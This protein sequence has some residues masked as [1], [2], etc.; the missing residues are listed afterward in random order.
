MIDGGLFPEVI[1]SRNIQGVPSVYLNGEVFAN[2]KID[3]A[4]LLEKLI[5]KY[6]ITVKS[7]KPSLPLQDVTVIGGGPAGVA[8]AIYSARK[9][10]N[11]TMIADRI[12][13]QVKD[14]MGIEN[15]ISVP[16]TTGP[17]LSNALQGHMDDYDIT[18]KSGL[19]VTQVEKGEIKRIHL[20][21]GEVIESKTMIIATGAKWREL[22]IP[23]E[24]EN[25]GNGVAYCPHCDGPFFKVKDVAVVGGGNSGI[26]AALDLA[27]IVKSVTVFEFMPELK[28]DSVLVKQAEARDNIT[29]LKNV[30]TKRIIADNGK[31]TSLEY[32]D[33]ETQELHFKELSG[34]FI[35]I[36]LVPNSAFLKDVLELSQY[37]EV[38]IDE[39]GRTSEPGIFAC[40]DVTTVPYKQIVIAMGEGAKASLAAFDYLLMHS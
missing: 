32:Q 35:Q 38:V 16:K 11:V 39:R 10:L 40:G 5:Q 9:G 12:G 3:Q 37:G 24:K 28:A 7:D 31:V 30:A 15:L 19:K 1:S 26:E 8:A 2:G 25:I 27:G 20:S 36:G 18:L 29:I 33:R 13:G 6:P 17:E 4:V 23:G 21:S 22:G 14:T 34:V